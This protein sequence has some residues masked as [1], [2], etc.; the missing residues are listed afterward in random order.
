MLAFASRRLAL[1]AAVLAI[2]A[3]TL[4][5]LIA[6]IDIADIRRTANE[7]RLVLVEVRVR[8]GSGLWL[9]LAAGI[10]GIVGAVLLL[11]RRRS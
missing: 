11:V 6:V 5:I 10:V 3:S 7:P 9:T 2:V 1:W 4:L 8:V